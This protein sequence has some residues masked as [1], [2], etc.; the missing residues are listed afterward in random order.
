MPRISLSRGLDVFALI[1]ADSDEAKGFT[2]YLGY[3][4]GLARLIDDVYGP[5]PAPAI[6]AEMLSR[7]AVK[8]LQAKKFTGDTRELASVLLNGWAQE[9]ALYAVDDDDPRLM[10]QNLW[11]NV[12]AY[13]AVSSS[14]RAFLM[15]RQGSAPDNHRRTLTALSGLVTDSFLFPTPWGLAC[16]CEQNLAF[17][18]FPR[19]PAECSNLEVAAD[20]L[21]IVA[22][23]LKTTR[24]REVQ[25][26]VDQAK[27]EQKLDRAPRGLRE[28]IED[29]LEATTL[30]EFMWRNR[31]RSNYGDPSMFYV[32]SLSEDR[33]RRYVQGVRSVTAASM[34]VFETLVAQRA[35]GVLLD[36]AVHFMS[37]DRSQLSDLLIGDRLRTI[38]LLND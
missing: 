24:R 26:R 1:D 4:D 3:W 22:K 8:K 25:R 20:P 28:S 36:A 37:R 14:A 31:T 18:G 13:Y 23:A 19:E 38:G 15:V 27:T 7:K 35:P 21:D 17:G 29:R 30:F 16:T 12:Y 10:L 6:V 2:T 34:L 32:G 11:N 33:S 5:D 9:V